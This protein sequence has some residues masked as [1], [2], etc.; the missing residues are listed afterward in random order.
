MK[1]ET[2]ETERETKN[3]KSTNLNSSSGVKQFTIN[4][5]QTTPLNLTIA[6]NPIQGSLQITKT[7]ATTKAPLQGATFNVLNESGAVVGTGTTNTQG[8]LTINNLPL[9]N[10]TYVETVA[11]L[12][13]IVNS[14]AEPFTIKANG[15]VV[16]EEVTNEVMKGSLEITKIDAVTKAPLQG[17]KFN[18]LNSVGKVVGTGTTNV[19]GQLTISNLP[20]GSY[21]YVEIA[22]P[23]GYVLNNTPVSFS[24]TTNGQVVT[25]NVANQEMK[26]SLEITK[27]DAVT[28][29]PLQGAIFNVLNA[30]ETVVETGTTNAQGQLIISNLPAGNYTYVETTAP[31]GYVLNNTPVPF[32][33]TTN[34]QV[35]TANIANQA[36]EGSLE[37]IKTDGTTGAPL[38]CAKFIVKN[39]QNNIVACGWTNSQGKLCFSLP[40]G[41]YT[42]Q[43]VCAPKGYETNT[44]AILFEIN[45]SN[46]VV[47]ANV[48]NQAITPLPVNNNG[49]LKITKVDLCNIGEVLPGAQFKIINSNGNIVQTVVTNNQGVAEVSLPAGVYYVIEIKAPMGYGICRTKRRITV[50]AGKTSELLSRNRKLNN[51][52]QCNHCCYNPCNFPNSKMIPP[53][54]NNGILKITKVDLCNIGEVLQGAQF[55]IVDCNGNIVQTVVTNNQGV[56]EASLPAGVYHVMEIKAPIGYGICKTRRKITIMAGKTSELLSRDIKVN[57]CSYPY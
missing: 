29:T 52:C 1:P 15:H 27:I 23:A 37:I 18:V 56:A 8:Q 53:V 42:Y 50:M 36:M 51:C 7:D 19:Q 45:A 30:S 25:E 34:G 20:L 31:T 4:Q 10:Y 44:T 35:V 55:Q 49:I 21:T 11:P 2:N 33:I 24:I 47:T 32:S 28:K 14:I 9:G 57:G 3:L 43:E 17:A 38:S 26:G 40:Y 22:A 54:N 5:G 41:S 16:V 48:T 12:G 39:N 6:N 46:Q 13:Y